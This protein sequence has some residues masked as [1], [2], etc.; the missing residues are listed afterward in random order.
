MEIS[1]SDKDKIFFSA[2]DEV[3]NKGKVFVIYKNEKPIADLIPH[4]RKS[5]ITPHPIMSK[6]KINYNPTETLSQDEWS[7]EK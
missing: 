7:E 3:E 5:R 6:I 2:L 1:I 4:K